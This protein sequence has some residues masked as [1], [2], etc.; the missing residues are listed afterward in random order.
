MNVTD[1]VM[2]RKTVRDFLS[3]PIP[4][5][6]IRELL[7]KASRAPSGGNVQPWKIWVINDESM[8]A[9]RQHMADEPSSKSMEYDIYPAKLW[10]PYRTYRFELGEQMYD[11]IGVGRDDK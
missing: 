3:D 9:F 2:K 7:E 8:A 10:D 6:T 4:S 1:A 11:T 5:E